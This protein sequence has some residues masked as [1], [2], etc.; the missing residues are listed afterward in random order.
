VRIGKSYYEINDLNVRMDVV[1][2]PITHSHMWISND[3]QVSCISQSAFLDQKP[4]IM[5]YEK[6]SST[7][8]MVG[9]YL[10]IGYAL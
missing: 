8:P 6:D 10:L 9:H 4:Y 3:M 2:C 7:Y 1:N 5:I